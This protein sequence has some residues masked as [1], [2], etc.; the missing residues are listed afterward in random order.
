MIPIEVKTMKH[1]PSILFVLCTLTAVMAIT[2]LARPATPRK[3]FCLDMV[4][5]MILV[6]S[7][8]PGGY[9]GFLI[10]GIVGA[11]IGSIIGALVGVVIMMWFSCLL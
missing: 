1:L 10:G 2:T 3:K 6:E 11:F 7:I 4:R 9:C 8:L 5:W